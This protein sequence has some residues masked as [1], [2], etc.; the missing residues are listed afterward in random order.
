MSSCTIAM[1][2][3]IVSRFKKLQLLS[4]ETGRASG[5]VNFA[6]KVS[7]KKKFIIYFPAPNLGPAPPCIYMHY[8]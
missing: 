1:L 6:L 4:V 2:Q 8:N 7:R 5:S 3:T